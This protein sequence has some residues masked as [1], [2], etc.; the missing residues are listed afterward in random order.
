ML[1]PI[2]SLPARGEPLLMCPQHTEN[3]KCAN[4][5]RVRACHN[6]ILWRHVLIIIM[7]D[8]SG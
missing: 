4:L 1:A 5:R 2:S 3:A 6:I 8:D 7:T